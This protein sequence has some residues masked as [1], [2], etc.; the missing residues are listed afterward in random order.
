MEHITF[1]PRQP[2]PNTSPFI[3]SPLA[4]MP[5]L[6]S[7][8]QTP[9]SS[10]LT[11]PSVNISTKTILKPPFA[12][13]F[14]PQFGGFIADKLQNYYNR[15][16]L[17]KMAP[18]LKK[19]NEL[20]ATVKPEVLSDE[21]LKA[22][23]TEFK[24]RLVEI[25]GKPLDQLNPQTEAPAIQAA[26]NEIMPEVYAVAREA[27][28]RTLHMRPYDVQMMAGIA[29]HQSKTVEMKTGE[30]KT[31]SAVMPIYLNAL[32]GRGAHVV[33]ANE[34]LAKRDAEEMGQ[35]YKALGLSV[36]VITEQQSKADKRQAYASDITYGT[37]SEFGF[38]YLRD[39]IGVFRPEDKVQRGFFYAIVDEADSI[40][41]DEA[42][43]P[44]IISAQS[45]GWM[46]TAKLFKETNRVAEQMIENVDYELDRKKQ[47]IEITDE[48]L[49]KA[50]KLLG[51]K[52]NR[53]QNNPLF[54][55]SQ[56]IRAK[57]FY[58]LDHQY[59]INDKKI[60]IVDEF[61]GRVS[62]G[63]RWSE[64]LHLAIECKEAMA[65]K[66]VEIQG[67]TDTDASVTYQNFFRLYPKL[68]GMTGT[69]A[70]DAQEFHKVFGIPVVVVPTNLPYIQEKLPDIYAPTRIEKF[71]LV[72]QDVEAVH[73]TGRPILVGTGS[74]E[75]S[76]F[77]SAMLIE[78]GIP[79][80]VLN[81][82]NHAKEAQIV[83]DAGR[84]GAV[85]IATNMAGRGTD[86]KLGGNKES[87]AKHI[88]EEVNGLTLVNTDAGVYKKYYDLALQLA[89]KQVQ[90]EKTKVVGLNG[91]YVI[92][93]ER[94]DSRR[95]DNQLAGRCARQ[96]DPGS[97]RFYLSPEDKLVK[98]HGNPSFWKWIGKAF[99]PP[100]EN[101]VAE[102]RSLESGFLSRKV[103]QFQKDVESRHYEDRKHLL[104]YDEVLDL[105][106]RKVY[107]ERDKMILATTSE[108][109][110]PYITNLL[111]PTIQKV[112]NDIQP[113]I[114]RLGRLK[115]DEREALA[116]AFFFREPVPEDKIPELRAFEIVQELS[117]YTGI[118]FEE[119]FNATSKE[120][121]E[122]V[123]QKYTDKLM[124][125][126]MSLKEKVG[127]KATAQFFKEVLVTNMDSHWK[128]YL[129]AVV[130]LQ[131]TIQMEAYAQ[132][133]PYLTYQ[134]ETPRM[135]SQMKL[136][137]TWSS[138]GG[139]LG[140]P[141]QLALNPG[142]APMVEMTLRI[143]EIAEKKPE[144]AE[145]LFE[146]K[147]APIPP[148]EYNPIFGSLYIEYY[149]IA[150]ELMTDPALKETFGEL[151][152]KIQ[153]LV[154][155]FVEEASADEA[156]IQQ[157]E[158]KTEAEVPK[159]EPLP[160]QGETTEPAKLP[161]DPT[162]PPKVTL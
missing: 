137:E 24:N 115:Q 127:D 136:Q 51:Y 30:G 147:R 129:N 36:G 162:T 35:V 65:G 49:E 84:V 57:E 118:A 146:F 130:S 148:L 113:M 108:E 80:N 38:D 152:K 125:E 145:R 121:P 12:E 110:K 59:V 21:A 79:H 16:E 64:G 98:V 58:H 8:G 101:P 14:Q 31:L 72:A 91:L 81:A 54:A 103:T 131:E 85:T 112:L 153:T 6:L 156:G 23:T 142:V 88:M 33:T 138:L 123:A 157:P 19:I 28:Q 44:L 63:R 154:K 71:A 17:T 119:I 77:L 135:Y 94:F 3:R 114:E 10:P 96:G 75:D 116:K 134:L 5:P 87:L 122:E 144:L 15:A 61:T 97:V 161:V 141:R 7:A 93:T 92:G 82:K 67:E 53:R 159:T 126:V 45:N 124:S 60:K 109:F 74:I 100:A 73:K 48:G 47:S 43:T 132:K 34:Y 95:I 150:E 18:A 11:A 160:T 2:H 120:K 41:I 62:D 128:D 151:G 105:H 99:D 25:L 66:D 102:P 139:L 1:K 78:K 149:E 68:G 106:R 158:A 40:L 111:Q 90:E 39:H 42:R 55:L 140:L 27:C 46:D 104:K 76:E 37:H 107:E 20:E 4:S 9:L 117:Q 50:E 32:L 143:N 89:K 13:R 70:T 86:I 133:D 69:A 52:L 56:S 155:P 29:L 22:K 83:A 26:L